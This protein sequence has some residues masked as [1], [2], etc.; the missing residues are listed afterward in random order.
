[1]H[2]AA[3]CRI[4]HDRQPHF[5][6]ALPSERFL[7][8]PYDLVQVIPLGFTAPASP[9]SGEVFIAAEV[10]WDGVVDVLDAIQFFCD[11]INEAPSADLD[12]NGQVTADDLTIM[13]DSLSNRP[14][15]AR[16][17]NGPGREY[18]DFAWHQRHCPAM[19]QQGYSLA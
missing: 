14:H 19:T 11:Y 18:C 4:T 9:P 7:T 8:S 5:I 6:E 15:L 3:V 10:N 17:G 12:L 16:A 13:L 1:M 2:G